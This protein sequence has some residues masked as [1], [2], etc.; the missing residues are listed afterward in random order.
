MPQ[1]RVFSTSQ[2]EL[3]GLGGGEGINALGREMAI[4]EE[5]EM[6]AEP[7]RRFPPRGGRGGGGGGGEAGTAQHQPCNLLF[8]NT[9]S[10]FDPIYFKGRQ[11]KARLKMHNQRMDQAREEQALLQTRLRSFNG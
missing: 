9:R 11:K 6:Q 2:T 4:R 3:P 10:S 5:G 8:L 1:K 7:A